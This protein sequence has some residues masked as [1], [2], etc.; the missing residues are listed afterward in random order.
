MSER[1]IDLRV[2]LE[3][4]AHLLREPCS[5]TDRQHAR[6]LVERLRRI[7]ESPASQGRDPE[8]VRLSKGLHDLMGVTT[9]RNPDG[10]DQ[11]VDSALLI[12]KELRDR[13]SGEPSDEELA[14]LAN[15]HE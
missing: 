2:E 3:R 5:S 10:V 6:L 14:R 8:L 9:G 11:T 1:A 15:H 7:P 4:L 13:G 12:V